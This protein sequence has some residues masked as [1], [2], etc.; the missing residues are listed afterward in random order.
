MCKKRWTGGR[1][2]ILQ[3]GVWALAQGQLATSGCPLATARSL[4]DCGLA[5]TAPYFQLFGFFF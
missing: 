4:S 1:R 2:K 3:E 5:P